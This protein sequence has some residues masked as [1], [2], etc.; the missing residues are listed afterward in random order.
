MDEFNMVYIVMC[1]RTLVS[2]AD[3]ES[4]FPDLYKWDSDNWQHV[5]LN[6]L[7]YENKTQANK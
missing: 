2:A 7:K 6:L 4:V 5:V 3:L 1:Y